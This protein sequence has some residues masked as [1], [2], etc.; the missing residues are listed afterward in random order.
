MLSYTQVVCI[1]TMIDFVCLFEIQRSQ[2]LHI[3]IELF[4][5]NG[6]LGIDQKRFTNS[7]LVKTAVP[8]VM[9]DMI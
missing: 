7:V 3:E 5:G 1:Q 2:K 4:K 9:W 6:I 8:D